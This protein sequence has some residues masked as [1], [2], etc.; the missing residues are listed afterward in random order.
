MPIL[1]GRVCVFYKVSFTSCMQ[2]DTG[3]EPLRRFQTMFMAL[4]WLR[5]CLTYDSQ[6]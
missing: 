4:L 5:C 1:G 2:V 3:R 6:L